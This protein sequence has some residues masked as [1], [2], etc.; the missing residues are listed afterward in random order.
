MGRHAY[1]TRI[2]PESKTR[3]KTSGRGA[4][5]ERFRTT[6][7]GGGRCCCWTGNRGCLQSAR[8]SNEMLAARELLTIPLLFAFFCSSYFP[9]FCYSR[10]GF[11]FSSLPRL[12]WSF[13]DIFFSSPV[14]VLSLFVT[15]YSL[16]TGFVK[17]VIFLSRF[18][19][20]FFFSKTIKINTYFQFS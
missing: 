3:G 12:Y 16:S 4:Y 7:T 15:V 10:I 2:A 14:A 6:F 19:Q 17:K 20:F 13:S 18:I 5:D 9:F 11:S 8:S 1:N